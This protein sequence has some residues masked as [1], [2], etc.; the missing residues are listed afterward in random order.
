MPKKVTFVLRPIIIILEEE[1]RKGP[2][3]YIALDRYRFNRRIMDIEHK[4]GW[5]LKPL[6]REKIWEKLVHIP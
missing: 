3:E 2:W 5:C 4:I 6:H 1:D